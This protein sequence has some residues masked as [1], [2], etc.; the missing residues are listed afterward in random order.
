[1]E[2]VNLPPS[3]SQA[4]PNPAPSAKSATPAPTTQPAKPITNAVIHTVSGKTIENGYVVFDKGRITAVGEAAA[5][6]RLTNEV[7]VIDATG[8]HVYPGF[9]SAVTGTWW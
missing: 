4:L 7:R 1:M 6:P 5:L 8:K 9:V 2:V 3:N